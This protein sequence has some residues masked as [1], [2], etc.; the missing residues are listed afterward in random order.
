MSALSIQPTYP[1]FTET[2]GQPLEDGYIW[3]G[4]ANLDPEGNPINVYWD[5]ALTQMASQ[6]IRTQGGYPVNNG[7]P[8]R[9]YVNSDYSI[10][11]MS[12]FGI[13]VYIAPAA[14]ERYSDVVIADID[15]SKVSFIQAG[16]GAVTRTAQSKM[17]ESVNVLDFGAVMDDP[18]SRAVNK[19][20]LVNAMNT[21][22][23]INVPAGVLWVDNDIEFVSDT[24]L[25]GEGALLTTIKGSGDLFKVTTGFG[26]GTF[27]G[28][29]LE[30]DAT[31][32][33]LYT[34]T[35]PNDSGHARFIDVNFGDATYHI[36]H[37]TGFAAVSPI[38]ENCVFR[39]AT[40]NSRY[41]R[42]LWAYKETNCYNWYNGAGLVVEGT[43]MG[44]SVNN[45][46]FEHHTNEA[47]KLSVVSAGNEQLSFSVNNTYFEFNGKAGTPDV[48]LITSAAGRIR[49]VDFNNCIIQNP[50]VSTTPVRVYLSAGG[51][52][53]IDQIVFSS[54]SVIGTLPLVTDASNVTLRNT[55]IAAGTSSYVNVRIP[56]LAEGAIGQVAPRATPS[57]AWNTDFT[58]DSVSIA[59]GATYDL[60]VGSGLI[61]FIAVGSVGTAAGVVLCAFGTT[62]L[63]ATTLA[64]VT[65]T[66][67]TANKMNVFYNAGTGRYRLEN[68]LG[69]DVVLSISMD[70]LRS[71]V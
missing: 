34:L 23:K 40:I 58:Q 1:I 53:N 62:T 6:P 29:T 59:N 9:L 14:T 5:A 2:D 46:V 56:N 49:A 63:V 61:S 43:S 25:C 67:G 31:L 45:S 21:G 44:C 8:A 16:T 26:S 30:N 24:Y 12:K 68:L 11:V 3:I 35:P 19:T 22:K 42:S 70:K 55:Y 65:V 20:A 7:T 52:G 18:L 66:P 48:T 71:V 39:G 32:G 60:A 47:M 38:F 33:K 69:N 10:R 51:G 17:R 4:T 28:L 36:F 13:T 57:V 27:Q 41:Y 15:S 37:A 64:S 50:D 54:C